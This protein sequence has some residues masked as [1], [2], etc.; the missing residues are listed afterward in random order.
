MK[1]FDTVQNYGKIVQLPGYGMTL[2]INGLL[3][4]YDF[5]G[6][7]GSGY[8]NVNLRGSLMNAGEYAPY[9]TTFIDS[10]IHHLSALDR[11]PFGGEWYSDNSNGPVVALSDLVFKNAYINLSF[12]RNTILNANGHQL[13]FD[14]TRFYGTSVS[15]SDSLWF[16]NRTSVYNVDFLTTANIYG[17]MNLDNN[18]RFLDTLNNYGEIQNVL[19]FGRTL[20]VLEC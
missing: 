16:V 12:S 4:N 11:T 15:N 18:V 5:V 13:I 10:N 2:H 6:S 17:T 9:R 7:I 20:D 3:E 19:W 14:S 1:F 8:L